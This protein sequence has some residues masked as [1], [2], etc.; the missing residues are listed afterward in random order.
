MSWRN[1]ANAF[2]M[3]LA[4]AHSRPVDACE[5]GTNTC[6]IQERA[7]CTYT[8]GSSYSCSCLPGFS[9]DGRTCQGTAKKKKKKISATIA[10]T[11]LGF[12]D[13]VQSRCGGMLLPGLQICNSADPLEGCNCKGICRGLEEVTLRATQHICSGLAAK[14]GKQM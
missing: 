11:S 4:S 3:F 1:V 13:L 7:R 12:P 10:V 9:G 8:G 2:L 5:E 14:H 6:D